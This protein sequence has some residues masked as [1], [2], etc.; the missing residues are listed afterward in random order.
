MRKLSP[1]PALAVFAAAGPPLFAAITV[2]VGLLKP[3]YD[4]A[5][6]TVS[7]LAVGDYGW[8]QNA[9]FLLLGGAMIAFAVLLRTR[10]GALFGFAGAAVIAAAFY[11]TDLAGAPETSHGATHNMLF[12]L[13]FLALITAFALHGSKLTAL[14]VFT[15]LFVFVMFAGDVGDPLHSVAGLIERAV[16]AIPLVWISFS[17]AQQLQAV[18]PGIRRVEAADAR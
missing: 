8:I 14:T 4:I 1:S 12:L 10:R 18:A 16:I 15:G 3:G 6:Q 2:L 7:D 11:E 5:E 17:A 9:N 13:I